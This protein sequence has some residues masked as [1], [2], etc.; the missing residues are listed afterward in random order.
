MAG[1]KFSLEPVLAYRESVVELLQ[2]ELATLEQEARQARAMR[3]DLIAEMEQSKTDLQD[4]FHRDRL[5]VDAVTRVELYRQGLSVRLQQQQAVVADL[6]AQVAGKREEL[7]KAQQDREVLEELKR[8]QLRHFK[9]RV[10][11]AEARLIDESAIAGFNRHRRGNS[12]VDG[13]S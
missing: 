6:E 11:Q 13:S 9:Q 8:R 2:M 1:F 12:D 10:E 7:L 4:L 3:D 5:D